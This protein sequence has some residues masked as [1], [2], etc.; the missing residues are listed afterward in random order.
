MDVDQSDYVDKDELEGF[1]KMIEVRPPLPPL[2]SLIPEGFLKMIEVSCHV[3]S[4]P[5]ACHS[6][7]CHLPL[8]TPL[9][10]PLVTR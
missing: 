9:A 1:L 5:L 6:A 3:A 2:P 10:I 8:A 7:T 4:L